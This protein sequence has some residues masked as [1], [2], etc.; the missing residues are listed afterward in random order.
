[1]QFIKVHNRLWNTQELKFITFAADPEGTL[2][3]EFYNGYNP[4]IPDYL[5]TVEW[6]IR[7][8]LWNK[9]KQFLDI[10]Y[11]IET[12]SEYLSRKTYCEKQRKFQEQEY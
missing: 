2:Y 7:D 8:F 4:S 3:L 9:E 10:D 5:G 11:F 1:M 6:E 12:D